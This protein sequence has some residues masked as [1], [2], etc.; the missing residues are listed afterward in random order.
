[1]RKANKKNRSLNIQSGDE[2]IEKKMK[3]QF[4]TESRRSTRL[5]LQRLATSVDQF[6]IY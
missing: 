5:E 1:M 3:R 2:R 4:V 6:S